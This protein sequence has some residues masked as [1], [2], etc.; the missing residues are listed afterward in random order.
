MPTT[1]K[2]ALAHSPARQRLGRKEAG[3]GDGGK[4]ELTV[5]DLNEQIAKSVKTALGEVITLD[6]VKSAVA[7]AITAAETAAKA[8]KQKLTADNVEGIIADSIKRANTLIE[9][10][11]A[12]GDDDDK[13]EGTAE[14]KAAKAAKAALAATGGATLADIE[15]IVKKCLKG[16]KQ[17]S[18]REFE[19]E[20]G[21][22]DDPHGYFIPD[23]E[24]AGNL[25]VCHKQLLNC[26]LSKGIDE[27]IPSDLMKKATRRG[28]TELDGLRRKRFGGFRAVSGF[29]A[30]TVAGSGTGAEWVPSDLSSELYR[31]L[32]M[33]SPLAQYMMAR[34]IVM[35]TDNYQYPLR[36]TRP[37]WYGR[38]NCRCKRW[39]AAPCF[40]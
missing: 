10:A 14:E 21:E 31:R 7:E 40:R 25:T 20:G 34:E 16:Y 13:G 22:G 27:G 28:E 33:A 1:R 24:R 30:L 9:E 32:Y 35:P 11:A 38:G 6:Q 4:K 26:V 39:R 23:G 37:R 19:G 8:A 36:T 5:A 17:P 3:G 2:S 12:A 15:A 18:R 29:K